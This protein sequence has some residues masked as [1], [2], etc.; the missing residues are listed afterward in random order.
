VKVS[1]LCLAV[2]S[3]ALMASAAFAQDQ[4]AS[5]AAPAAPPPAARQG[6]PPPPPPP[7]GWPV[8]GQPVEYLPKSA[9]GQHQDPAWPTQTRAPY[10]PSKTKFQVQTFASGLE[11][12]WGM[13]FLPDGRMLV[14][15]RPGRIRIVDK[16]GSLSPPIDGVPPVHIQQISG[17]QDVVLDPHYAQNHVIYWT[18][19]E[20]RSPEDGSKVATGVALAK[21]RLVDGPQPRVEDVQIIYRQR[22]D[23]VTEHSNYGGRMVF[24]ADGYLYLTLG[25]RD[26]LEWRPYIQQLDNGVGKI[27]RLKT[28]GSP[29]PGGPFAHIV[30]ARPEIWAYGFRN[31]LGITFR[32]DTGQLWAVDVGPRGGDYLLLIKPGK[33]YG[34]PLSRFGQ[35]YSGEQVGQG[36][37]L[38]GMEEPVYYWDPVISPSSVIFYDGKMFPEWRG[39]AFVTSLTQKHL[40]RLVMK[41]DRVAGEERLLADQGER[42]REVKEGPDGSLYVITDNAKGRI[43]RI[44]K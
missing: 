44:T 32:D 21:G 33:D 20:A 27:V 39:N 36:P 17:M 6:P 12:P 5:A 38:K 3:A 31:T 10:M 23:L 13:A 41:G 11:D 9:Q 15:E 14:T 4:A 30:G 43:L 35:E 34:W 2:A 7:P 26:S 37:H 29:A 19:V 18:F 24:G 42:L 8:P 16:D 25:D 40:V 22:P 28:D 1:T